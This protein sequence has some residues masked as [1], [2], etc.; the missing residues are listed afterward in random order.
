MIKYCYLLFFSVVLVSCSNDDPGDVILSAEDINVNGTKY[1]ESKNSFDNTYSILIETINSMDS[2]TLITEVD[3]AANARSVGRVLGPTKIIF[4]QNAELETSLLQKNQLS[5]LELPQSILLFENSLNSV[6]AIY[7]SM[8]YLE[9]RYGLQGVSA[10]SEISIELEYLVT[11]ATSSAI[12]RATD[13]AVT[14]EAGIITVISSKSFEDTYSNLQSNIA[15]NENLSIVAE[16]DH[17]ENSASV[18]LEL[19]PTKLVIFGN[20]SLGSPLMQNKQ[21]VG[22][23]LPQ[24]ILVWE[25]ENAVVKISYNDPYYL[26]QRYD[27]Q[28]NQE[29]L[30]QISEALT[31]LAKAAAGN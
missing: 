20:P 17:Q 12:K 3:H 23:D 31:N 21:V 10:L 24:K 14:E 6:Y 27:L 16:I 26:Q 13:L 29:E 9:S 25:D 11:T 30:D 7:N 28:K 19:R 2:V 22:L 15:E 1:S 18:G 5:G 4:F 8:P